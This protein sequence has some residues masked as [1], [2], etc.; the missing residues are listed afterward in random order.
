MIK[1]YFIEEQSTSTEACNSFL[2]L[3]QEA[4]RQNYLVAVE[5]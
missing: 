3:F 5:V 4:S 2:V 1:I